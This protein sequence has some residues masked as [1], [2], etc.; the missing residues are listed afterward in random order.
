MNDV[1]G[2]GLIDSIQGIRASQFAAGM[3]TIPP[4][5]VPRSLQAPRCASMQQPPR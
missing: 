3:A 4:T 5:T 2:A 1:A